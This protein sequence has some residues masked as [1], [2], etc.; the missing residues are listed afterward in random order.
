[1][2]FLR[3]WWKYSEIRK[4]M[5]AHLREYTNKHWTVIKGLFLCYL[6]Y[7][8]IKKWVKEMKKENNH[9]DSK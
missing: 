3:E 4:L 7:I 2:G 9:I 5:A 8:A 1:M 6:N